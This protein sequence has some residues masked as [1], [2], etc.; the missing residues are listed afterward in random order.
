M[1]AGADSTVGAMHRPGAAGSDRHDP[2]PSRRGEPPALLARRDPVVH[3]GAHA[4]FGPL[5][6]EQVDHFD[7]HGYV[8]VRELFSPGEVER[9]DAAVDD[10]VADLTDDDVERLIVEPSSKEVRSVFQFHDPPAHHRQGLLD[11][12]ASDERLAGVARQLLGSQ[13]Y[14]HQSRVNRKPALRGRDFQWHSDFETWHTEDGMPTPRCL[15]ASVWLTDNH[16]WNGPLL[17]MPGSH[18]TFV[19]CPEP[20]PADNHERSLRAQEIGVPDDESLFATYERCGIAPATGP[21]GS[22]LFFDSNLLHA[23]SSNISPLSR[24]NLFL[25]Y[26]SVANRLEEPFAAPG[27][28]PAHLASRSVAPV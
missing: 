22:V 15:S 11:K 20:T 9:L 28:R 7:R 16:T 1:T 8:V 26:N 10:L 13:V 4:G 25:V 2:Y 17:V 27:R 14:V 19:T 12:V 18:R 5:D 3:D 23:S 21:A 6:D 24:R